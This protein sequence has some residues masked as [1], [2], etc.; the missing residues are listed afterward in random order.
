[1]TV[2]LPRRL[3]HSW[4]TFSRSSINHEDPVTRSDRLVLPSSATDDDW[5]AAP[6]NVELRLESNF[7]QIAS[8]SCSVTRLLKMLK[9]SRR[10]KVP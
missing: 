10:I 6:W 7:A 4:L 2:S 5:S 9:A 3:S 8:F 1:M